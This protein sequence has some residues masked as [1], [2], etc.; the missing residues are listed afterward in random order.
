[1]ADPALALPA[2][3]TAADVAARCGVSLDVVYRLLDEG[4]IPARRI[5]RQWRVHPEALETWLRNADAHPHTPCA[6]TTAAAPGGS[7]SLN[8]GEAANDS[9]SGSPPPTSRRPKRTASLP[10]ASG[11][12]PSLLARLKAAAKL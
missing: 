5:G 8:A 2:L 4:A 6:S 3:L 1:V 10:R 7:T 12:A 11:R 9:P